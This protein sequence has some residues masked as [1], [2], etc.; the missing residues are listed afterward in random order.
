[1]DDMTELSQRIGKLRI[2]RGISQVRLGRAIGVSTTAIFKLESGESRMLRADHLLRIA[3]ELN[4][5][6]YA[7]LLGEHSPEFRQLGLSHSHTESVSL[8]GLRPDRRRLLA[9]IIETFLE[10]AEGQ[11]KHAGS[12]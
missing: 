7:L 5:N 1:M 6:P 11:K 10:E 3:L 8:S 12:S 4:A 9:W 2:E